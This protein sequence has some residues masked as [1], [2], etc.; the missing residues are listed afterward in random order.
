[1]GI[2]A[3]VS[4]RAQR[5]VHEEVIRRINTAARYVAHILKKRVADFMMMKGYSERVA[6]ALVEESSRDYRLLSRVIVEEEHGIK[7]EFLENP[8][9]VGLYTGSFY[10]LGSFI[11]LIPYF[12]SLSIN[13]AILLSLSLAAIALALTGAIIAILAGMN[14]K[15]KS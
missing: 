4:T 10:A 8:V 12:L 7:E 14:I 15:E 1:M 5:E 2:G 9:R 11:S 13:V 6:K 3:L